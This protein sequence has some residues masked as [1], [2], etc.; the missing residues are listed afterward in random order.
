MHDLCEEGPDRFRSGHA[1]V[2]GELGGLGDD[3]GPDVASEARVLGD[4]ADQVLRTS[5]REL[6]GEEGTEEAGGR[7]APGRARRVTT[8]GE[9]LR[10]FPGGMHSLQDDPCR[11][12]GHRERVRLR[13]FRPCLE[14]W[15]TLAAPES[16][17]HF[18]GGPKRISLACLAGSEVRRWTPG[19]GAPSLPRGMPWTCASPAGSPSTTSSAWFARG[20]GSRREESAGTWSTGRG[21]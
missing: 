4:R 18:R 9:D 6:E 3:V 19:G 20:A 7:Q 11:R 5:A 16:I 21:T 8:S 12:I 2:V 10:V 17:F 15:P 14:R 1:E 13:A